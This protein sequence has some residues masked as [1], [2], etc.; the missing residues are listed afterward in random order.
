M[1]IQ[2]PYPFSPI[3]YSHKLN[4]SGLRYEIGIGLSSQNIVWVSGPFRCG[5]I[6]DLDIFRSDLR[7]QLLDNENVIADDGYP[8]RKCMRKCSVTA[9][10]D[11]SFIERALSRH[12]TLNGRLKFFNILNIPFRHNI[13]K[14][15]ACFFAVASITQVILTYE[16]PLFQI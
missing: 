4:G 12:E 1:P 16:S 3:W 8:D 7:Y 5:Q 11:I 14:H 6:N 10:E 15:S 2:E 9:P 13:E